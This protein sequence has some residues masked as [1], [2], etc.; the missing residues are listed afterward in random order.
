MNDEQ[1]TINYGPLAGLIGTWQGDKG[2]DLAPEPDGSE[3]SPYHETLTFEPIG[4]VCNAERQT[5][6]VLHYRQ[7]VRR[8]SNNEVF[9]DQTGYWMW[10][11]DTATVVHSL[12]IPRAVGL[13]AGGQ[14]GEAPDNG[15]II[16]DVSAGIDNPDWGI[17]QSPFMRDNA[18]TVAFTLRLTL[19]KDRLSYSETTTLDI[20]GRTF[21]HTDANELVRC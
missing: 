17:V 8:N 21:E 20:Y 15:A 16:L 9:H 14:H 7:I 6:T 12:V 2:L 11:E 10:D 3:T 1:T 18:K 13:L 19:E 5:L 4:D